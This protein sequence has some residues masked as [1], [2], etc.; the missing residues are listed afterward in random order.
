MGRQDGF[1]AKVIA[2]VSDF[3]FA[4]VTIH[5]CHKD[6]LI[7]CRLTCSDSCSKVMEEGCSWWAGIP[8]AE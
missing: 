8:L 4:D 3:H 1:M 6:N 7:T 2:D 5:I